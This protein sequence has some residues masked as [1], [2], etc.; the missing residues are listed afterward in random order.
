MIILTE[1]QIRT[2][3]ELTNIEM[4][5]EDASTNRD[6]EKILSTVKRLLAAGISSAMIL[7]MLNNA[8]VSS[9]IKHEVEEILS[10]ETVD[11]TYDKQVDAVGRYMDMIT[12]Y[13]GY[14][15]EN[16]EISP[17]TIVTA[18]R[19]Y[20]Y[21]LPLLL[22]QANLES[23]FGLSDRAKRTNSVFSVGCQ[24]NG[25]DICHYA[26]QDDSIEAYIRLILRDYLVDGKTIQDLL[27]NF[28]NK[29]NER[30]ASD[31]NYEKNLNIVRN[32]IIRE[33]PELTK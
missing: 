11:S 6:R 18:A 24:D 28:V 7:S 12:R 19:K 20:N 17:D 27:K 22:A 32:R 1:S 21:D 14:N 4:I 26:T 16:I 29:R 3:A 5:L 9:S 23:C 10:T 31:K 8:H 2:F 25:K 30:Y 33:F 15:P 13:R